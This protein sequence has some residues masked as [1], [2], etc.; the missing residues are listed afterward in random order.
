MK[1]KELRGRYFYRRWLAIVAALA[2]ALAAAQFTFTAQASADV[3]GTECSGGAI[4]I[5]AH[6]DDDLLFQS[7]DILRD[8]DQGRCVRTVYVTAGDSGYEDDYWQSRES[9]AE[10]A[11][12]Q[13]AGVSN[14]WTTSTISLAGKSVR[15]RT[16]KSAP[17]VTLIFM[18]LPDGFPLGTGSA[19]Q[20][21]QSLYRLLTGAISTVTAVDGSTSY[22]ST[23]LRNSLLAAIQ[24][25]DYTW[26]R[27]QDYVTYYGGDQDHYDHHAVAFLARD[28]TG[29]YTNDCVLSSYLGYGDFLL[30][31]A[32]PANIASS[33]LT[34][35]TSIFTTYAKYD[36]EVDISEY[37]QRGWL[38]RQYVIAINGDAAAANAG[39]DQTVTA[40]STVTLNGTG[41]TGVSGLTYNWSQTSGTTVALSS[42]S[43]STATFTPTT[44]GSY[45]FTLTATSGGTSST[46]S[47]T[48]TVTGASAASSSSAPST[49]A[50]SSGSSSA[51]SNLAMVGA[52][53]T[54]S[55]E[56]AGQEG[57]KAVDG[58]AKGYPGYDSNEWSTDGGGAGSWITLTWNTPVTLSK[59]V[60]YDRPNS[61][62]RITAGTLVFSDGSSVAVGQLNNDGSATTVSFTARTVTSVQLQIT[63]VASKTENVGLAEF[64]AWGTAAS[65]APSTTTS[66]P[67]TAAPTTTAPSTTAP[68][69]TAPT[70]TAPTTTAPTTTAPTTSAPSTA[71]NVARQSTVKV[72]ASS[73]QS[74]SKAAKAVDGVIS[75]YP[76]DATK[77][78]ATDRGK[79]GSWIT[80]TWSSA[81]TVNKIVLYDRPNLDDQ[82]LSGTLVFSDGSTIAVGQLN[83]DGTATTVSFDPKK[84]TSVQ[85]KVD[86]VSSSTYEVGLAEF[87]VYASQ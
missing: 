74:S 66:A 85:F 86:S 31:G 75:G 28:A 32:W 52:T 34:R 82:V 18:R 58:V 12:A 84:I 61:N 76:A 69:T 13:A 87:E 15:M 1:T 10:A 77:E 72:T 22:T 81:V 73:Q 54:Q 64:E 25:N 70:T 43:A 53:V 55:S 42:T 60:L 8:V 67:T 9:G 37:Q 62:D 79:A 50:S 65:T 20:G 33:D 23:T 27:T 44:A 59:V 48:I 57:K 30:N 24:D 46:D 68:S 6:Q 56:V 2:L 21:Y 49:S 40:G 36:D 38:A 19:A 41:S 11:W 29:Y 14:S 78:W 39:L 51:L 45:V 71:T 26:V 83:N 47:V 5:I 80:L 63:K 4:Q 7:P 3:I 35:K 17:N 16:L